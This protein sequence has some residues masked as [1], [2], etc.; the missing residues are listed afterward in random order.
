M[1]LVTNVLGKR[2]LTN[3]QAGRLYKLRWGIELQFR[4]VKQTCGRHKLRSRPPA[5]TYVELY[6]SLVGLWLIQLFA[7]KEQLESGEVPKHCSV[8]LAIQVIRETF[9]RW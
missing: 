4:T 1:H 9:R 5:R 2:A 3:A 7:V 6:W 8:V